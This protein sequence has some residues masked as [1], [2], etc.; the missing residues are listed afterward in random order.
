MGYANPKPKR[1]LNPNPSTKSVLFCGEF[2]HLPSL[3]LTSGLSVSY[4]SLIFSRRREPTLFASEKIAKALKMGLEEFLMGLRG[5]V[6][7]SHLS[8]PA[9]FAKLP[10]PRPRMTKKR[11][12]Y[13]LEIEAEEAA[14][15]KAEEEAEEKEIN[16]NPL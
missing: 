10:L 4:L 5:H 13:H 8:E 9:K 3:H 15:A 6:A 7:R 11:I 14:I 12:A 16:N 1:C 2:I